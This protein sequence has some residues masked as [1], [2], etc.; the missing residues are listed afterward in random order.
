VVEKLGAC[1]KKRTADSQLTRQYSLPTMFP[2]KAELEKDAHKHARHYANVR[3]FSRSEARH[4]WKVF[5]NQKNHNTEDF[6]DADSDGDNIAL[7]QDHPP[8]TSI[9]HKKRDKCLADFSR[10][11]DRNL[12]DALFPPGVTLETL[13]EEGNTYILHP[14]KSE[15][16]TRKGRTDMCLV[17]HFDRTRPELDVVVT[18]GGGSKNRSQ[19][20]AAILCRRL[21]E[22][23][24][25][26]GDMWQLDVQRP[27]RH[28]PSAD[29]RFVMGHTNV[30]YRLC[31]DEEERLI[32]FC[33]GYASD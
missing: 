18:G 12:E 6:D 15:K 2:D 23:D 33:N 25:H 13:A 7:F 16:F 8:G 3:Q 1:Q 28:V 22:L 4:D 10:G 30:D 19:S 9:N 26:D 29:F 5:P 17:P 32:L 27:E 21:N 24:N 31:D 11:P 14:E 20:C